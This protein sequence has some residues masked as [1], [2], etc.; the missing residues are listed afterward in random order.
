MTGLCYPF[1][2]HSTES[3]KEINSTPAAAYS[4]KY[5]LQEYLI[6][7][8]MKQALDTFCYFLELHQQYLVTSL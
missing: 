3:S 8:I 5:S 4:L 7:G 2:A 1:R 6:K